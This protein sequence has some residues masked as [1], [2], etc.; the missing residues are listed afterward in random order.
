MFLILLIR[1]FVSSI[2]VSYRML[3][4]FNTYVS[5]GMNQMLWIGLFYICFFGR[6]KQFLFYTCCCIGPTRSPSP[7]SPVGGSGLYPS[8]RQQMTADTQ[9]S[10][11]SSLV[12]PP[13]GSVPASSTPA[14]AN[15]PVSGPEATLGYAQKVPHLSMPPTSQQPKASCRAVYD[16]E[17]ENEG[18]LEFKEGDIITLTD[19]IDVRETVFSFVFWNYFERIMSCNVSFWILVV[20]KLVR[21]SCT[22]QKRS[23]SCNVCRSHRRPSKEV[24]WT[25]CWNKKSLGARF[26]SNP[27]HVFIRSECFKVLS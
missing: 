17:P 8:A 23:L 10:F 2:S 1:F 22:W 26:D 6:C 9:I 14:T 19:R 13:K 25:L 16:F 12:P 5:H 7:L 11:G 20:G 18:E 21:R 3:F 15:T 27:S 4:G 24:N